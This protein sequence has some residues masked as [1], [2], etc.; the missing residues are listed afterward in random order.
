MK[1]KKTAIIFG[2][3]GQDGAYLS[4]FLLKKGYKVFVGLENK[5]YKIKKYS[6]LD[7]Y[8]K[9]KTVGYNIFATTSKEF[10]IKL[11]DDS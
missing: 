10:L 3:S 1:I 8:K 9:R 6:D 4:H 7:K 5:F 2:I 11:E